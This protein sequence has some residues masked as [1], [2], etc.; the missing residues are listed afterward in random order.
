MAPVIKAALIPLR[1]GQ[2]VGGNDAAEAEA[3]HGRHGEES[4]LA[5]GR[6]ETD[7]SNKLTN[8]TGADRAL[9]AD[10]VGHRAPSLPA[11]KSE[12]EQRRE[13]RRGDRCGNPDI[14][15]EGHKMALWHRHRHAAKTRCGKHR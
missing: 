10:P 14:D 3:E 9:P 2:H 11:Q 12:P 15:A 1:Y 8:G 13:H 4:G 7:H 6:Q 5:L